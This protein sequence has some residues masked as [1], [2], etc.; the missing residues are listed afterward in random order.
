MTTLEQDTR[1]VEC[2]YL[3]E[4]KYSLFAQTGVHVSEK[5]MMDWLAPQLDSIY[6][7]MNMSKNWMVNMV[8][9]APIYHTDI[10]ECLVQAIEL[11]LKDK[12]TD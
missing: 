5:E 10:T 8:C 11:V 1:L 2:G 3:S 4:E 7:P 6:P 12:R 9:K